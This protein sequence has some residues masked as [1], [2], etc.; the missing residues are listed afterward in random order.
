M[1]E[2]VEQ[3]GPLNTLKLAYIYPKRFYFVAKD[4]E[5]LSSHFEVREHGFLQG[6]RKF[7]PWHFLRQLLFL[8]SAKLRGIEHVIAHFAGY[9]TLLP[10]LLGFKTHIIVAGSDAC[11]FPAMN[12]G[13]FRKKWMRR[14]MA[15]SMRNAVTILP[16]HHSLARFTNT[17]SDQGPEQQG[18]AH[19]V[20]DLHTPSVSIPYGFDVDQWSIK[21]G[22]RNPRSVISVAFGARCG[23]P[24]FVRKGLDLIL[25]AAR[26]MPEFEFTLVGLDELS[27]Y[28]NMPAN[29]TCY[30]R[31]DPVRL[32]ELFGSH[33][34][35]AQPS[36]MEGFPNALCEAMLCGCIPVVSDVTSMPEIIG[37]VGKVIHKRSSSELIN[38]LREVSGGSD[39]WTTNARTLARA[40]VIGYTMSKRIEL[41][42]GIL[43]R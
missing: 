1:S 29:V 38:A 9:H 25:D 21:L 35:Y 13:S 16:V 36:V 31:V 17:Y 8:G 18:Y 40:Q 5:Y 26:A 14:A 12:Y 22:P 27:G 30:G 39:E 19:F 20:T 23:D 2:P 43:F 37:K 6:P 24:V 15:Y 34:I 42:T 32:R 33:S 4:I 28:M 41:L 3:T 10:T 7:L 11:S